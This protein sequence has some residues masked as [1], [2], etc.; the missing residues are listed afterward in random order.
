MPSVTYEMHK[1]VGIVLFHTFLNILV[2][3][4]KCSSTL[5]PFRNL[6]NRSTSLLTQLF[7]TFTIPKSRTEVLS[8]GFTQFSKMNQVWEKLLI[9]LINNSIRRKPKSRFEELIFHKILIEELNFLGSRILKKS[10]N[11]LGHLKSPVISDFPQ[12]HIKKVTRKRTI[13]QHNNDKLKK[14]FSLNCGKI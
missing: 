7:T 13:N 1:K 6:P 9:S 5:R 4:K 2:Q 10:I 11:I 12:I 8:K 14:K 3:L